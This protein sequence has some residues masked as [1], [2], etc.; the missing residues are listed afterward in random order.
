MT[1]LPPQVQC[2]IREPAL[3]AEVA[4]CFCQHFLPK[5]ETEQML[6]RRMHTTTRRISVLKVDWGPLPFP[7]IAFGGDAIQVRQISMLEADPPPPPH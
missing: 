6:N 4:V 5:F 3:S 1:A 2:Y 7:S